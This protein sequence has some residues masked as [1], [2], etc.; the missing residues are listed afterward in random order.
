MLE[1]LDQPPRSDL[2]NS[3][4]SLKALERI[5]NGV[6]DPTESP[7]ERIVSLVRKAG[8]AIIQLVKHH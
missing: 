5:A 7:V 6:S 1:G 2:V 8:S 3:P 4:A